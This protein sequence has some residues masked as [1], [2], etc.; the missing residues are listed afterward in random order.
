[1]KKLAPGDSGTWVTDSSG[2][3]LVGHIVCSDVFGDASVVPYSSVLPYIVRSCSFASAGLPT[4]EELHEWQIRLRKLSSDS[5]VVANISTPSMQ[6]VGEY[7]DNRE[8]KAM[9]ANRH[10]VSFMDGYNPLCPNY[11]PLLPITKK[12]RMVPEMYHSSSSANHQF[13]AP[14][15]S[16]YQQYFSTESTDQ[17]LPCNT[18]QLGNLP[19]DASEGEIKSLFSQQRGF[20]RLCVRMKQSGSV[21]FVEFEDAKFATEALNHLHGHLL[22]NSIKGG[23]RL[24]FSKNPLGIRSGE[25]QGNS[26]PSLPPAG[27]STLDVSGPQFSSAPGLALSASLP[28]ASEF[29]ALSASA[30][31]T[32]STGPYRTSS[33]P[34]S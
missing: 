19:V 20:K 9:S 1:M 7:D 32:S 34:A 13:F 24:S 10:I 31:L 2:E 23:I 14:A 33:L 8:T 5:L 3:G 22:R 29:T 28:L 30:T 6:N 27:F 18:L 17:N 15:S 11:N 16:R 26:V 12:S 21:C 4:A 25:Q